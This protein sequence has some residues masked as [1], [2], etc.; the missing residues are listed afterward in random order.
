MFHITTQHPLL[1]SIVL[2]AVV[3]TLSVDFLSMTDGEVR[4]DGQSSWFS[5]RPFCRCVER[6]FFS[7]ADVCPRRA[8]P[9]ACPFNCTSAGIVLLSVL[10]LCLP[11]PLTVGLAVCLERPLSVGDLSC[12][13]APVTLVVPASIDAARC[14]FFPA[15]FVLSS[16]D[17]RRR[18]SLA[19]D[20]REGSHDAAPL[21]DPVLL[22]DAVA[23]C[24]GV[25]DVVGCRASLFSSPNLSAITCSWSSI[26][27]TTIILFV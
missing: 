26:Y 25:V 4:G 10:W 21:F 2:A 24:R 19:L 3:P 23:C 1:L 14:P 7:S 20:R 15:G 6:R 11:P 13:L 22:E 27:N 18:S 17:R 12:Q 16:L 8:L 5:V 9:P